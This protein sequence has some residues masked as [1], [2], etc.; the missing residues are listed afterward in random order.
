[1]PLEKGIWEVVE[2]HF[3]GMPS[4]LCPSELGQL[5]VN[6][7]NMAPFWG[8]LS[9]DQLQ[10]CMKI[11]KGEQYSNVSGLDVKARPEAALNG[12]QVQCGVIGVRAAQRIRGGLVRFSLSDDE[13]LQD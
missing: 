8:L 1:M 5:E 9:A 10:K 11:Y 3:V 2:E 4:A 13:E 7:Y 6:T 12:L